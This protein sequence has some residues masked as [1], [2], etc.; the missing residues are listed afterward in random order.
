M[1]KM[2]F[3]GLLALAGCGS[4]EIVYL[5]KPGAPGVQCGPY[6]AL[7]GREAVLSERSLRS[8]VEDYQRQGYERIAAPTAP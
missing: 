3:A 2:A 1:R 4:A 7:T 6:R 5:A 8:C